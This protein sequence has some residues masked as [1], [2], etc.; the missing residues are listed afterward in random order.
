VVVFD[1]A[2]GR[3]VGDVGAEIGV[4]AARG[5]A[6]RDGP[7]EIDVAESRGTAGR[8]LA[9]FRRPLPAEMPFADAVGGVAVLLEESGGGE[10]AFFNERLTPGAEDLGFETGAPTVAAGEES[11]TRGGTDG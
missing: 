11:V 1:V 6:G 2:V 3:V 9:V 5:G 10:A 8:R 4:E 7:G